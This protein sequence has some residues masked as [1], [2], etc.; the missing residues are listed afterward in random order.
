MTGMLERAWARVLE[1]QEAIVASRQVSHEVRLFRHSVQC[2]TDCENGLWFA[3]MLLSVRWN[4]WRC[5]MKSKLYAGT[6]DCDAPEE[7]FWTP[8]DCWLQSRHI[9]CGWS[10]LFN[11][12]L[13]L[14]TVSKNK[15][16]P[17][18]HGATTQYWIFFT[19]PTIS[20]PTSLFLMLSTV[21]N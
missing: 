7:A 5:L 3:S 9:A 6:V 17:P 16:L 20:V 18:C 10:M 19:V 2:S 11:H 13:R 8:W 1:D 14:A 4:G 15:N 21:S 12:D